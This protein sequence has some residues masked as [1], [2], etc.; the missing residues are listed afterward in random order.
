M[1]RALAT[2]LILTGLGCYTQRDKAGASNMGGQWGGL[3]SLVMRRSNFSVIL[4]GFGPQTHGDEA[5]AL[6]MGG[7]G[8]KGET[9]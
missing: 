8:G 5:G 7:H 9:S 6:H 1:S 2:P 3:H 4:T